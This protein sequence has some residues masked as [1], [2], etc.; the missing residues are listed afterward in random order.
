M[1]I[2]FPFTEEEMLADPNFKSLTLTEAI[3]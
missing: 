3:E 2:D 1:W